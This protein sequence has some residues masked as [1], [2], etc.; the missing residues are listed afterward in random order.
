MQACT[1]SKSQRTKCSVSDVMRRLG[2]NPTEVGK[3]M[4][5]MMQQKSFVFQRLMEFMDLL[6]YYKNDVLTVVDSCR[7]FVDVFQDVRQTLCLST[8]D[9]F[10]QLNE[11]EVDI[12]KQRI[13]PDVCSNDAGDDD[14]GKLG[15]IRESQPAV[16]IKAKNMLMV[17]LKNNE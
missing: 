15:D 5:W 1:M 2:N 7:F 17:L 4:L 8:S 13:M 11:D 14:Y 12:A 3:L 16:P 6:I 9:P 10:Q